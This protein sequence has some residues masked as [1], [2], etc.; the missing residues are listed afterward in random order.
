MRCFH[1]AAKSPLG[2]KIVSFMEEDPD[3][4]KSEHG[5]DIS[6]LR[7]KEKAMM[8][9]ERM[10]L[11]R[12][13][14]RAKFV[15]KLCLF[16]GDL[17]ASYKSAASVQPARRGSR[18][19]RGALDRTPGLAE[20]AG[21]SNPKKPRKG[22]GNLATTTCYNCNGIQNIFFIFGYFK[23]FTGLLVS[24]CSFQSWAMSPTPAR[25]PR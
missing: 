7:A 18:G 11:G 8:Q 16:Q 25:S 23:T 12:F 5:M 21:A 3:L 14:F 19:H 2:W 13:S 6:E 15:G 20:G 22:K 10:F 17:S 24:F 9:H 4:D 1:Y